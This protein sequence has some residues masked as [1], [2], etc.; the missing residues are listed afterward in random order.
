MLDKA[1]IFY[2]LGYNTLLVDFMG[3]GGSEGNQT[4]IGY[5]EAEQ[6]KTAFEFLTLRGEKNIVLFG[7]SLGAVAI[8]KAQHD[9]QLTTKGIILEC[10]FGTMLETV[11]ARFASMKVPS[12]PMANLLVLWGGVQNG[13]NAFRHNPVDYAKSISTPTLLL[14][15]EKDERVSKN[16]I[17]RIFSNLQGVKTLK[18]YPLAGHENYL[19]KYAVEWKE[20]IT[21]L[22][23]GIAYSPVR[24][25]VLVTV[26]TESELC[27]APLGA[28]F[29]N[30]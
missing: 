20:D 17:D 3:S 30:G 28:T 9:Y 26:N 13:F 6:V 23:D 1:E 12:F 10:P 4:T 19:T 25:E 5:F 27:R 24:S 2:D 8:M 22:L 7:T 16:E 14:Y 15:G 18:T 21:L 11:Q 29:G